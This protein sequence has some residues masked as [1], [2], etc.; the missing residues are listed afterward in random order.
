MNL[1]LT[2]RLNS[3]VNQKGILK[4]NQIGFQKGC[5]TADHVLTIETIVDKYLSKNKN[6][7]F[8]FVDLKKAYNS[9]WRKGLFEKLY[10]YGVSEKFICPSRKYI[11]SNVQLGVRLPNVITNHFAS[12][13]GLK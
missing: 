9:I 2:S 8:C 3:F 10:S 1:L 12:N 7:Y 4:Y 5:R 11:Y 6:L 13:I